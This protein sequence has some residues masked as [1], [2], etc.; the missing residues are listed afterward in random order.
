MEKTR[1]IMWHCPAAAQGNRPQVPA[2]PIAA[3]VA[4][5]GLALMLAGCGGGTGAPEPEG[6]SP[7]LAGPAV[8]GRW[9]AFVGEGVVEAAPAPRLTGGE[10]EWFALFLASQDPED[11]SA[12]VHVFTQR[13]PP[14]QFQVTL[15]GRRLTAVDLLRRPEVPRGETF[16]IGVAADRPVFA[17]MVH[18]RPA[19]RDGV[20]ETLEAVVAVP[21][22]LTD[23]HR[24][25]IYP[26]GFQGGTADWQER[27]TLTVLNPGSRAGMARL[28]FRFRD[29]RPPLGT[30]VALPAGRVAAVRLWTLF[31]GQ[32]QQDPP[33]RGDYATLIEADV[34]VVSQQV[35]RVTRRGQTEMLG[36]R[37]ATPVPIAD[38]RAARRWYYAGGWTRPL[39]SSPGDA[40][41]HGW[42]LLFAYPLTAAPPAMTLDLHTAGGHVESRPVPLTA[43]RSDLQWLHEPP[44]RPAL[45]SGEPWGLVLTP[46]GAAA[47]SVTAAEY[48]PASLGL[49]GAM[50][51]ASLQPD[52]LASA[53][54]LG[55][56]REGPA[57]AAGARWEA[58]WQ[59]FNP[60]ERP[61]AVTL[62][63]LRT[64]APEVSKTVEVAPGAVVR[65]HAQEIPELTDGT[66]FVVYAEGDGPFAAYTWVRV[67]AGAEDTPRALTGFPG[68]ALEGGA[69]PLAAAGRISDR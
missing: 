24:T 23:R 37:P 58:A 14:R 39:R 44:W 45:P 40:F 1:E 17:Q 49:P 12:D 19:G 9:H 27:E 6:S 43:G 15:T 18:G 21:G 62:H 60:T 2:V 66:P 64:A 50:S 8:S 48:E 57:M 47:P 35:R 10:P 5:A 20:P 11:R 28:S 16:W 51:A 52:P 26:D 36:S 42:Q 56:G 3:G 32:Q 68:M 4:I 41:A 59:L 22:P 29:G 65:V 38:A 33:L 63:A 25:W 61:A 34:P 30:R 13:E 46:A 53:W 7:A 31:G 54:W 55:I 69:S 67:L